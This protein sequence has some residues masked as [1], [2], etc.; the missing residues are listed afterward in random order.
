MAQLAKKSACNVG[1]R[2]SIHGLGRSP[3]ERNNYPLQYSG[4]ENSMDYIVH[5]VANSQTGLSVFHFH[6]VVREETVLRQKGVQRRLCSRGSAGLTGAGL[7]SYQVERVQLGESTLPVCAFRK[8]SQRPT[9][10]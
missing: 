1:D 8:P 7:A 4:L 3:D 2:D 10:N 6:I 9:L 5:G